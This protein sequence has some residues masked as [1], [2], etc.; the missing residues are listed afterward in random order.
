VCGSLCDDTWPC[1]R[2][3]H[4]AVRLS[5]VCMAGRVATS[6]R[7][8]AWAVFAEVR[9]AAV[10]RRGAP[11]QAP[12]AKPGTW[13][14]AVIVNVLVIFYHF[15]RD[16][17][18]SPLATC[19]S[20]IS[21]DTGMVYRDMSS[22]RGVSNCQWSISVGPCPFRGNACVT[23]LF[24]LSDGCSAEVWLQSHSLRLSTLR[25]LSLLLGSMN[26]FR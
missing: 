25:S 2:S 22:C 13:N 10:Q 20:D 3:A 26:G 8:A 11:V 7:L 24:K 14:V 16:N 21:T 6:G 23:L 15:A 19:C 4:S 1:D 5:A 12:R 17:S 9:H 18:S